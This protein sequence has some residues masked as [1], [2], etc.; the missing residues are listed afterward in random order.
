MTR[1]KVIFI[2]WQARFDELVEQAKTAA[3]RD[4]QWKIEQARRVLEEEG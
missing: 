4:K 3:E 1:I 2:A